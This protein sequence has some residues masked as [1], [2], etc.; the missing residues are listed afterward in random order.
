ME[1]S[2]WAILLLV[3]GVAFLM[4]EVFIPSGGVIS[5]LS[6]VCLLSGVYQAW[7]AWSKS[8]PVLFVAYLMV[9]LLMVPVGVVV[10]FYMWP[11]TKLGKQALLSGPTPEE[12]EAFG[13][14]ER[15]HAELV[16]RVGTTVS[17]LNPAGLVRID[18]KR[19]VCQSDGSIIEN[20]QTVKVVA[21][22]T[23]FVVVR[24]HT[25]SPEELA[26]SQ[27]PA[28]PVEPLATEPTPDASTPAPTPTSEPDRIDFDMT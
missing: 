21:A 6:A 16:G 23:N 18:G 14:I 8:S 15:E 3:V 26:P 24:A 25:P 10:A 1:A 4:A 9:M 19:V 22:R 27:K 13:D 12:I 7:S 5:I 20:G 11:H 17:V 28:V 2:I